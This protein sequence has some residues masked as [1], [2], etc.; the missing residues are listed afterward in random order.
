MALQISL[1]NQKGGVSK[2]TT[3]FNLGSILVRVEEKITYWVRPVGEGLMKLIGFLM[4]KVLAG[5]IGSNGTAAPC[6]DRHKSAQS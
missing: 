2:T 3:A 6:L 4:C 1:F 5:L